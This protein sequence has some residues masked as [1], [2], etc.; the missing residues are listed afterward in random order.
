MLPF[1]SACAELG[2]VLSLGR[3]PAETSSTFTPS[4]SSSLSSLLNSPQGNPSLS[5]FS[6]SSSLVGSH[7]CSRC[8]CPS[9]SLSLSIIHGPPA[10]ESILSTL[11]VL[12][13]PLRPMELDSL[14]PGICILTSS[15]HA[16]SASGSWEAL[17]LWPLKLFRTSFQNLH[18]L[19]LLL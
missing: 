5:L 7:F 6:E 13:H 10:W 8:W 11:K 15:L 9:S 12:A 16:S 2:V 14:G 3:N 17:V 18:L 4:P 1:N 19:F